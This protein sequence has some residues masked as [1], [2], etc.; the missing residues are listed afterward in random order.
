MGQLEAKVRLN[1]FAPSNRRAVASATF[2]AFVES[3]RPI[4]DLYKSICDDDLLCIVEM[5]CEE[6]RAIKTPQYSHIENAEIV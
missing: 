2:A 3:G 1:A 6:K 4:S 5:L